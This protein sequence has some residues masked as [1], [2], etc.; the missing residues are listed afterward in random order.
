[1]ITSDQRKSLKNILQDVDFIF[2][3][4]N[5]CLLIIG[6]AWGVYTEGESVTVMKYIKSFFL[7]LGGISLL[8]GLKLNITP[9]PYPTFLHLVLFFFWVILISFIGENV[10]FAI[11]RS[12]ALFG[13]LFY[14]Y[15]VLHTLLIKYEP[16]VVLLAL[17]KGFNF[18]YALPLIG[19]LATG[20]HLEA[21]NIYGKNVIFYSNQYGWTSVIFILTTI[22]I[23]LLTKPKGSYRVY[24][25]FFSIVAI[26]LF[27]IAGNRSSW[28]SL[29][30]AFMVIIFRLKTMRLDYKIM[31]IT[32][33]VIAT[34]WMLSIPG[35]SINSRLIDT[36]NQ[37][38]GGEERLVVAKAGF[39]YLNENK[40]RWLTGAGMFN[41]EE[42]M[43][44][45]V[46]MQDYHNSYFEVLFGGGIVLFLLFLS[47]MLF[48][49]I[50][51]YAKYYSKYFTFLPPLAIIPFFESNL[52]GGQFLFFPWFSLMFL[53]NIPPGYKVTAHQKRKNQGSTKLHPKMVANNTR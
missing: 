1:M 12:L 2:L 48:R 50:T 4:I 17:I 36:E 26:Y 47:F 6:Y 21:S 46:D 14:V 22:D 42:V 3:M 44:G 25:I 29:I 35:S 34:I 7:G 5:A 27:F 16:L 9:I 33:P 19:F 39:D 30:F 13:P 23:W 32:I 53:L 49:P 40:I 18:V 31:I 41:Y 11:G 51:Y 20:V 8:R 43:Y 52:T 24:L 38:E 28:V 37:I 45:V 10:A 15:I